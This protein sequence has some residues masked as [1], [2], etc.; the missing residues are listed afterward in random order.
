MAASDKMY[1]LMSP[2]K[3]ALLGFAVT[4]SPG[5]LTR[6]GTQALNKAVEQMTENIE[7]N[8]AENLANV[9]NSIGPNNGSPVPPPPPPPQAENGDDFTEDSQDDIIK[10]QNLDNQVK[11]ATAQEAA[12]NKPKNSAPEEAPP[13][14]SKTPTEGFDENGNQIDNLDAPQKAE[15]FRGTMQ[16]LNAEGE[17]EELPPERGLITQTVNAIRYAPQIKIVKQK[18]QEAQK[19]L[20]TLENQQNS[21]VKEIRPLESKKNWMQK[22]KRVLSVA[23]TILKIFIRTGGCCIGFP[24]VIP[25]K[26]FQIA[27]EVKMKSLTTMIKELNTKIAKLEFQRLKIGDAVQKA[28]EKLQEID[29]QLYKLENQ[30]LFGG[31]DPTI[32]GKGAQA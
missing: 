17:Q 27:L 6:A 32:S 28:K 29:I 10:R 21:I 23:K 22:Q 3:N 9:V 14:S 1:K 8:A 25:A 30:A 26:A 2:L 12:K 5:I 11:Q 20:Q 7:H 15:K 4:I 16:P 13:P 31:S 24:L 19:R 18:R